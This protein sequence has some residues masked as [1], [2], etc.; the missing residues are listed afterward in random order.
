MFM[1]SVLAIAFASFFVGSAYADESEACGCVTTRAA[2][3]NDI[4]N[5]I[6]STGD[7]FMSSK[8]GFNAV[9]AGQKISEDAE[10]IVG[11][12]AVAQIKVGQTCDLLLSAGSEVQIVAAG[13]NL[14]VRAAETAKNCG[15]GT[16]T[17]SVNGSGTLSSAKS[18]TNGGPSLGLPE[19]LFGATAATWFAGELWSDDT[20][21]PASP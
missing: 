15:G 20:P 11:C 4:G 12:Q 19:V 7:V 9:A 13:S 16:K 1:R 5:I 2:S 17:G 3:G 14:C 21:P 6:S 18:Q 8:S 10:I